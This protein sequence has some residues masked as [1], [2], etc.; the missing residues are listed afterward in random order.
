MVDE[1]S[2]IHRTCPIPTGEKMTDVL[3]P[4]QRQRCMSN[5]KGKDTKPEMIV[6]KWLWSNGFRYRLH[7]R[8]LPGKPD[9]VFSG[10]RKV[11]FIH[12][13][14]WHKHSCRFFKWPGT[15]VDFW[16]GKITGN[17]DRDKRNQSSLK[18]SGWKVLVVWE[19]ETKQAS[20]E[21]LWRR[22]R[23]FLEEDHTGK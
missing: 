13:C 10:R 1:H 7:G 17:V 11:I 23:R 4:A 19:C 6:R 21:K 5:I 15:N 20:Q 16:K 22:I 14:F 8:N 9:I 18:K 2:G 3:T 12:G